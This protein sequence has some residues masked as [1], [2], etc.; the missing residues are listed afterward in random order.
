MLHQVDFFYIDSKC[1]KICKFVK[2][3]QLIN[4]EIMILFIQS[5]FLG[6]A[7]HCPK[8]GVILYL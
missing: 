3:M 1:T 7:F 6:L 2:K 5:I 4:F 8:S